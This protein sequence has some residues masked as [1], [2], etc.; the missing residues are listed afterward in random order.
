MKKI[1]GKEEL[2]MIVQE[3]YATLCDLDIKRAYEISRL[4]YLRKDMNPVIV[5]NLF[6]SML[7]G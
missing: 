7:D 3:A 4:K 2:S 6:V 1:Q 5:I